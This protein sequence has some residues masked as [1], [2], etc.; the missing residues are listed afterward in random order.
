M[1]KLGRIWQV[2]QQKILILDLVFVA[3]GI[4]ILT[5]KIQLGGGSNVVKILN[6]SLQ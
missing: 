2:K 3:I 4:Q 5:W 6:I 1:E